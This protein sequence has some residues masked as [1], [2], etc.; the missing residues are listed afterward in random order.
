MAQAHDGARARQ[1]A[2]EPQPHARLASAYDDKALLW[3]F[4]LLARAMERPARASV[5][6]CSANASKVHLPALDPI[7]PP[8]RPAHLHRSVL[9]GGLRA[10]LRFVPFGFPLY[11]H[12]RGQLPLVPGKDALPALKNAPGSPYVYTT[13]C[14]VGL[15]CTGWALP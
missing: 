12:P 3:Y 2:Q 10:V 11:D 7:R 15:R 14:V 1:R 6:R 8:L 4:G 13:N 5:W 9:L